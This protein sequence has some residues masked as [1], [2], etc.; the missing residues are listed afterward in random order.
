MGENEHY[1]TVNFPKPDP[2]A[3]DAVTQP[4]H[5]D[6]DMKEVAALWNSGEGMI[7]DAKERTMMDEHYMPKSLKTEIANAKAERERAKKKPLAVTQTDECPLRYKQGAHK[8]RCTIK[9]T[10]SHD[11][12]PAE[13]TNKQMSRCDEW[14]AIQSYHASRCRE[15]P[16]RQHLADRVM[17]EE[18]KE[19]K[20]E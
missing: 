9:F 11:D 19:G 14:Q 16:T 6:L 12:Y 3:L 2:A 1:S 20:D 17:I 5:H 15:C 7:Q 10:G 13:C 4:K 18:C 8:G